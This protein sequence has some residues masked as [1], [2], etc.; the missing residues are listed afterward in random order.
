MIDLNVST[1]IYSPAKQVFDF[2]ST[3]ENDFKWQYGNLATAKFSKGVSNIGTSYRSI[4]HLLGRRNIGTFEV[5]EYVPNKKY[6]FKSISG[7]FQS[8]TSY[9]FEMADRGTKIN[10]SM[11]SKVVNFFQMDEGVLEKRMKKQLK[12]NLAT[13]KDLLEV[14]RVQAFMSN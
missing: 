5:T 3:P 6:G 8:Q 9:T 2:V 7:P 11:Q 10:I 1:L 12:E 14:K 13:L 4:A